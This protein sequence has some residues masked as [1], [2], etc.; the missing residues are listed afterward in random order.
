MKDVYEAVRAGPGWNSTLLLVTYD[1]AGCFY[2]HDVPP[3]EGVPHDG[4]LCNRGNATTPTMCEAC[5][6]HGS[7]PF[8][9]RRLGLRVPAILVSPWVAK[10]VAIQRP[11]NQARKSSNNS[12]FEHSSISATLKQL[13]NLTSFLTARDAWAGSFDELLVDKPRSNT[14]CP[15]HLPTAPNASSPWGVPPSSAAA[16]A[17]ARRRRQLLGDVNGNSKNDEQHCS[18]TAEQ[19]CT[20]EVLMSEK[21]RNQAA[22]LASLTGRAAPTGQSGGEAGAIEAA[23]WLAARWDE[24]VYS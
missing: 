8:D 16:A 9:F 10:G 14:D 12:Q 22:V 24:F 7:Q 23:D 1:D 3:S 18:P 6:G 17:E 13:F 11:S 4:A 20:E 2:D 15:M 21:Q 5:C 19:K